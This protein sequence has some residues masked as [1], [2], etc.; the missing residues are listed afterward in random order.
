MTSYYEKGERDRRRNEW[1]G[2]VVLACSV[3]TLFFGLFFGL[4][5]LLQWVA[6]VFA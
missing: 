1:V 5:F 3:P 4:N 6:R 2:L